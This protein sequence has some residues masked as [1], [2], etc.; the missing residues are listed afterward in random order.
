MFGPHRLVGGREL[1][2]GERRCEVRTAWIGLLLVATFTARAR[3]QL[4]VAAAAAVVVVVV[5]AAAKSSGFPRPWLL[6]H[7]F[8]ASFQLCVEGD[9]PHCRCL[10]GFV[11]GLVGCLADWS[12]LGR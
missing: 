10:Y 5:Q 6:R 1:S 2:P 7:R 4:V 9:L 11:E 8:G 3:P 12:L